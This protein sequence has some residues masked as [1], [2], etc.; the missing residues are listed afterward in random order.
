[1]R[2]QGSLLVLALTVGLSTFPAFATSIKIRGNSSEGIGTGSGSWNISGLLGSTTAL[3]YNTANVYPSA[4]VLSLGNGAFEQL[5]CSSNSQCA[6]GDGTPL[7]FLFQVP[8]TQIKNGTITFTNFT[9]SIADVFSQSCDGGDFQGPGFLCS[10]FANGT[11]NLSI[12]GNLNGK[13][14]TLTI[15]GSLQNISSLTFL[16]QEANDSSTLS[17]PRLA[18]VPEPASIS[19]VGSGLAAIFVRRRSRGRKI[20]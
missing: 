16:L 9:G 1:M 13:T 2:L 10:T 15:S 11:G 14:L 18:A 20:G 19:L 7:D 3:N 17:G 6:V 12:D 4:S 8:V 5:S